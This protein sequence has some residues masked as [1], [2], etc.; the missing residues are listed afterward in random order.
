MVNA[1]AQTSQISGFVTAAIAEKEKLKLD[2]SV[3]VGYLI[4]PE[5][6]PIKKISE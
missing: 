5:P 6:N 2:A 3:S 1:I 4:V